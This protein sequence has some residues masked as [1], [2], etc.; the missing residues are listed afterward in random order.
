MKK[1]I[2]IINLNDSECRNIGTIEVNDNVLSSFKKAVESH[3]CGEMKAVT[4]ETQD[5][6]VITDCISA[7]PIDVVVE[8]DIDGDEAEYYLELS[9]TW[10]YSGEEPD[11]FPENLDPWIETYYEVVKAIEREMREDELSGVVGLRYAEFG[12][13][14]LYDLAKDLTNEFQSMNK[15]RAWDGDFFD[16][17]DRFLAEKLYP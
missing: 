2:T 9:E 14:G 6:S 8:M 4:F 1:Y 5:A 16:E 13:G 3:F 11:Q 12:Y 10:L 15:G 17:I 7:N